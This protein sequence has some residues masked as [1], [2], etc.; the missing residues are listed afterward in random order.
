MDSGDGN[1][2]AI[3]IPSSQWVSSLALRAN[4]FDAVAST[5]STS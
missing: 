5:F 2:G 4:A 1:R 3:R